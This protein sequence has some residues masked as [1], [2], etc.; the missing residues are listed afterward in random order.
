MNEHVEAITQF[1]Q[2]F[3]AHLAELNRLTGPS[4]AFWDV[5]LGKLKH[6][7][8][9]LAFEV[10]ILVDARR[11]LVVTAQGHI[12]AF[13]LVEAIVANAPPVSNWVFTALKPPMGFAFTTT[14]EGI[15][16]DPRKMWFLPLK[17]AVRPMALGLR[18]FI[19][20]F[21]PRIKREAENAIMIILDTALGERMAALVDHVEVAEL[22]SSPEDEGYIRFYDLPKYIE[23]YMRKH[24]QH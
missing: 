8:K 5:A 2:W 10:G 7:D 18:L 22:P 15:E 9:N 16:F 17:H 23:W 24:P 14:Y 11:D 1:W 12:D 20:G 21:E 3:Q 19:P 4:D 6:I 13:P